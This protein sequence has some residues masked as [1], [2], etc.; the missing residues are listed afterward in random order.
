M[1]ELVIV[2]SVSWMKKKKFILDNFK[3]S[4]IIWPYSIKKAIDYSK[5]PNNK[6]TLYLFIETMARSLLIANF[7]RVVI[8][9]TSLDLESIF[10]WK[11]IAIEH[12][13]KMI[14]II[15]D[16]PIEDCFPREDL[17]SKQI[18]KNILESGEKAEQL[19]QI[20]NMKNQ[21]I[22]DKFII[23]KAKAEE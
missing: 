6:E 21:K 3:K 2:M 8:D 13:Y 15:Y 19:K 10:F 18:I 5:I 16:V 12:D 4:Q 11:K 7:E 20:L 14:V 17:Q 23:I 9:E 22:V 1:K